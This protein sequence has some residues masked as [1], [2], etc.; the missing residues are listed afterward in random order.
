MDELHKSINLKNK[1]IGILREWDIY[2]KT[3]FIAHDNSS[4]IKNAIVSMTLDIESRTFTQHLCINK[5]LEE[6]NY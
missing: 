6:K 3:I 5:G 2:N 1:V 4:N